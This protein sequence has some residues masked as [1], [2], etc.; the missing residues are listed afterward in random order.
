VKTFLIIV[1]LM[2]NYTKAQTDVTTG[3]LNVKIVNNSFQQVKIEL[4]LV[5]PLCWNKNHQITDQFNN[6][7]LKLQVAMYG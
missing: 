2:I 6:S 3:E 1:A 4:N 7:I 5:S